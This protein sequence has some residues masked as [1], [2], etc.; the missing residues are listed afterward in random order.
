MFK[1]SINQHNKSGLVDYTSRQLYCGM[2]KVSSVK[3]TIKQ[4]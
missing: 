4:M 2:L 3:M 1:S